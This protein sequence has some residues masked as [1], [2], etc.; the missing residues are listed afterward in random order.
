M[1]GY[2]KLKFVILYQCQC[3]EQIDA[4]RGKNKNGS[5]DKKWSFRWPTKA[6]ALYFSKN[7]L[8]LFSLQRETFHKPNII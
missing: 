4:S 5:A 3:Y 1:K 2:K 8:Q 6:T 7:F